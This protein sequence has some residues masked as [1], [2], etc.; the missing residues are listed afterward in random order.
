M[1]ND[2]AIIADQK[3]YGSSR[4]AKILSNVNQKIKVLVRSDISGSSEAFSGAL[5]LFDP[6]KFYYRY[7]HTSSSLL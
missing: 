5:H 2:A 7:I 1:W 3:L 6:R 4:V